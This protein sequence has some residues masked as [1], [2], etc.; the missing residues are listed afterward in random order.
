MSATA[1]WAPVPF[2][3][4]R[5]AAMLGAVS[6]PIHTTVLPAAR[7]PRISSQMATAV[8]PKDAMSVTSEASAAA[9]ALA[10]A[11]PPAATAFLSSSP[12]MSHTVTLTS[13]ATSA[14]VMAVPCTPVA[15]TLIDICLSLESLFVCRM[16][17]PL[18]LKICRSLAL[19]GAERKAE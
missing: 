3:T 2:T 12:S 17:P 8:P 15:I 19:V 16:S 1:N 5:A 14:A 9:P 11:T 10:A 6:A 18:V 7:D 13:F 4:S